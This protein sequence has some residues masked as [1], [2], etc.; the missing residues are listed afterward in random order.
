MNASE[1]CLVVAHSRTSKLM[2]P[3]K[4]CSMFSASLSTGPTVQQGSPQQRIN[5]KP[6]TLSIKAKD[7]LRESANQ[8]MP[9]LSP[10]PCETCHGT[11]GCFPRDQIT[12]FRVSRF[13]AE[14]EDPHNIYDFYCSQVADVQQ[15]LSML[16]SAILLPSLV[17]FPMSGF[18]LW[19]SM[20]WFPFIFYL[21]PALGQSISCIPFSAVHSCTVHSLQSMVDTLQSILTCEP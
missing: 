17:T 5:P 7:T 10:R 13:R 2:I 16:L 15:L 21:L 12:G 8:A 6:Q 14:G 20:F 4:D 11:P 18:V 19:I 3:V 9:E 1:R